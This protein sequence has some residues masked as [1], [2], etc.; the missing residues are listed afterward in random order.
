MKKKE[1]YAVLELSEGASKAEIKKAYWRLSKQFHPDL[2]HDQQAHSKFIEINEAYEFLMQLTPIEV[3]SSTDN[4]INSE[5]EQVYFDAYKKKMRERAEQKAQMRYQ[6]FLRQEQAYK[7]SGLSDIVLL[8][9]MA[10]HLVLFPL[11]AF[12]FTS[13]SFLEFK[14]SDAQTSYSVFAYAVA[15]ILILYL[16]FNIKGFF[17][18]DKI[19]YTPNRIIKLFTTTTDATEN[20]WFCNSKPANS[21]VYSVELLILKG[22]K[23]K[24][25]G[26]RQH[27]ANYIDES[28]KINIP[29]SQKAFAIHALVSVIKVF[30]IILFLFF[31]NYTSIVWRIVVGL[32]IGMIFSQLIL[33]ISNTKSCI[34]YLLTVDLLIRICIWLGLLVLITS[35][36][37]SPFDFRTH[38]PIYLLIT[39]MILF[40]CLI[41]QINSLLFGN[42]I[43]RPILKQYPLIQQQTD[44]G[45]KLY[46]DIPVVSFIY[47]LIKWIIG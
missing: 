37:I 18:F 16:I 20:C 22:V 6:E 5:Y 27:Q 45:Y 42:K 29:R 11:I 43:F 15:V 14:N 30:S 44:I 39:V 34:S 31:A 38:D 47:T 2:N 1:C 35:F 41:M 3:F 10:L 36:S 17:Q 24:S 40:D 26:Y 7:E 8:L 13:P 12:L 9:R 32:G 19:Y 23:L 46:E 28:A 4:D 33:L 21:K 25:N